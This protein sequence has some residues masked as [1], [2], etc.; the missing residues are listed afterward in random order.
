MQPNIS[1]AQWLAHFRDVL[2]GDGTFNLP[3]AIQEENGPGTECLD[4]PLTPEETRKAIVHLKANKSPGPDEILAKMLKGSLDQMLPF[5]VQLLNRI[6][7]TG[8][9][10]TLVHGLEQLLSQYTI[11]ETKTILI[12]TDVSHLSAY[13]ERH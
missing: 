6:C 7:D 3:E 1:E 2:G 9:Y 5:L 4:S 13:W 12:I 11:A 10:P 8:H